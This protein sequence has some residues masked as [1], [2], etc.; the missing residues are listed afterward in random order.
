M[1]NRRSKNIT[2]RPMTSSTAPKPIQSFNMEA[3]G[4]QRVVKAKETASS[5][6]KAAAALRESADLVIL[7]QD[8][9]EV[10]AEEQPLTI[11][12]Q[13]LN[14]EL[15]GKPSVAATM[16][17]ELLD[18]VETSTPQ[19]SSS[20][21][22]QNEMLEQW[23][24]MFCNLYLDQLYQHHSPPFDNC[25]WCNEEQLADFRCDN[26]ITCPKFCKQCVLSRHVVSPTH[27][28]RRWTGSAWSRT[29]LG[30]EGLTITLGAHVS[31]CRLGHREAFTLGDLTGIHTVSVF[32]CGCT[33]APE[34][35]VQLLQ[36]QI[37]P[38]SDTRPSTGFTFA[39]MRMFHFASTES[40]QS[41]SRFFSTLQ[42]STNNIMPS[43]HA[44]RLR[45]FLRAVRIWTHLQ[46]LKHA[47]AVTQA[48]PQAKILALRCPAC[49][50]LGVNY[51]REDVVAGQ[52]FLYNQHIS[53]DGSFQ[54]TR[55]NKSYD[56]H[57]LCLSDGTM[58]WI[59][60]TSYKAYL[61]SIDDSAYKQSTRGS[62]CSNHRAA[63]DTWV[64]QIGVAES[65]VGGVT[66]GRHTFY[67]PSGMVNLFKGERFA[68]TDRAIVA[69]I[70]MLFLE[71]AVRIGIWYDIYCHWIKNFFDRLATL[72]IPDIPADVK[73]RIFG[74]VGKFH[75]VS[76]IDPCFAEYSP[77]HIEGVARID[78]EGS[79]RGWSDLNLAARSS[80]ETGPG[81]RIDSLNSTMNDWNWRKIILIVA[82]LLTKYAEAVRMAE[83]QEEQWQRFNASISLTLRTHWEGLSTKPYRD[84][85][86]GQM[87]SVFLSKESSA[88]SMTRTLLDLNELERKELK[89]S[90]DMEPGLTAPA[91]IS[92]GLEIEHQQ[93]HI[94]D[95]QK[96][97]CFNRRSTLSSRIIRHRNNALLFIDVVPSSSQRS[98]SLAEETDG[99][100]ELAK[101]YLLGRLGDQLSLTDR[102]K[103]VQKIEYKLRRVACLRAVHRLKTA[104]IQKAT[105]IQGKQ[106]HATGEIQNTRAQTLINRMSKRVDLAVWEYQN[107][108]TAL[109]ALG[110]TGK[111]AVKDTNLFQPL[112]AK[113]LKLLTTILTQDRN[114]GEGYKELP[115]FWSITAV[116]APDEEPEVKEQLNEANRL[117]WFRGRE[118]Y[119]R[120]REEEKF[121]RREM[122]SVI[123]D[124]CSRSEAWA[125]LA[126]SNDVKLRHGYRAY[127][128][129]QRDVWKQLS[130]NAFDR[131][132]HMLTAQ[133]EIALCKRVWEQCS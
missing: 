123:L 81:F 67:M 89:Q 3:S 107:S 37:L 72:M 45:E 2:G 83:E 128:M 130:E 33:N 19:K 101:L 125:A 100:P 85:K 108:R 133:P 25:L 86:T 39:A 26:C 47:G 55:K 84:P 122:A 61:E 87:T 64:R 1:P 23:T 46:N 65:G 132:K 79:E 124:F 11:L 117:E 21:K 103:R 5:K 14:E 111:E 27:R 59:N 57:D 88:T 77:N 38:C 42:R 91:W 106:E 102:S 28:I 58:Y 126:T 92:E 90:E 75:I 52:E 63:N 70:V 114:I 6:R 24:K 18:D 94:T 13:P 9:M 110:Q 109:F 44:N 62:A 98:D 36:A 119:K 7:N 22:G 29:S 20:G 80:S 104:A 30:E 17:D 95:H 113:D 116:D 68:Y 93:W 69:V 4:S 8:V 115:W 32:F 74:G 53:Y 78:A 15:I 71:G 76:H 82:L 112:L 66:C 31:P 120:W 73:E 16:L 43:L 105:L 96:L 34:S 51:F 118:R 121:L 99:Q 129:R 131:G 48:S 50:R 10:L 41:A 35:N 40:K 127:C 97:E 49:P 12:P 60:Q 56:E 54:L